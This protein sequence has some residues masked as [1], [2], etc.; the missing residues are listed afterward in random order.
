MEGLI[1]C[2]GYSVA[3]VTSQKSHFHEINSVGSYLSHPAAV[4]FPGLL[5]SKPSQ[6]LHGRDFLF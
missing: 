5:G 3:I 6:L 4:G 2:H 1:G